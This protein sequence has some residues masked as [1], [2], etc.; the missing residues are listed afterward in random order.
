TRPA[1]A[2]AALVE[3]FRPIRREQ[4]SAA[5]RANVLVVRDQARI[6]RVLQCH[7]VFSW[8]HPP[9][10]KCKNLPETCGNVV[11]QVSRATVW[12]TNVVRQHGGGTFADY[13]KLQLGVAALE[14]Q[15]MHLTRLCGLSLA[16]VFLSGGIASGQ[17]PP[18]PYVA[19]TPNLNPSSSLVVP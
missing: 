9:P 19:P 14:D 7:R 6:C 2:Y 12:R 13:F 5:L 10:R 4:P 17:V 18:A 3:M 15:S 16:T 8:R 11:T 1:V